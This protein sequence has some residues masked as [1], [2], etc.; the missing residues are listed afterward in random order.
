MSQLKFLFIGLPIVG[1]E[2]YQKL[3]TYIDNCF[4]PKVNDYCPHYWKIEVPL[5]EKQT[6]GLA[7]VFCENIE[8]N[9][10]HM[11]T[12]MTNLDFYRLDSKHTLRVLEQVTSIH[13]LPFLDYSLLFARKT[14]VEAMME[15]LSILPLDVIRLCT[16]YAHEIE[17]IQKGDFLHIQPSSSGSVD[18]LRVWIW[19]EE[20]L[21]LYKLKNDADHVSISSSI[22]ISFQREIFDCLK[23]LLFLLSK[24]QKSFYF[25][26]PH[27]LNPLTV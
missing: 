6:Q 23:N 9:V 26:R 19:E 27:V 24:G 1:E 18:H 14:K 11:E 16:S 10:E 12:I 13:P 7:Y 2:K 8:C 21:S 3:A 20:K 5:C 15:D 22:P 25:P 4:S 17:I